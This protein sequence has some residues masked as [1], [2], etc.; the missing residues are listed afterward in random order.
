MGHRDVAFSRALAEAR[1]LRAGIAI[2]RI[3]V[4]SDE[5][6]RGKPYPACFLPGAEKLDV[7]ASD[8]LVFEDTSAGLR[9]ADASSAAGLAIT[10]THA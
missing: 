3:L 9:A 2:P 8:C 10:F 1:L 4:T 5:L 6:D 7:D